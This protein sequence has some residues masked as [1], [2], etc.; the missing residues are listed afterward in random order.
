MHMWE[1]SEKCY[2][3]D[4]NREKC[5]YMRNRKA[6]RNR[7]KCDTITKHFKIHAIVHMRSQF[8]TKLVGLLSSRCLCR[9][10]QNACKYICTVQTLLP[11]SMTLS[12]IIMP[13]FCPLTSASA[14]SKND[15]LLA[16]SSW[17]SL[18]TIACVRVC[19]SVCDEIKDNHNA[20]LINAQQSKPPRQN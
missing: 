7:R 20:P 9:Q 12:H 8:H 17:C 19:V 16:P 15:K 14:P 13:A 10:K 2:V 4:E 6:E 11:S 5:G 18:R 3:C 1:N